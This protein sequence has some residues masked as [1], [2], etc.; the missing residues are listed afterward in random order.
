MIAKRRVLAFIAP[1]RS[2]CSVS[3]DVCTYNPACEKIVNWSIVRSCG[4]YEQWEREGTVEVAEF[5]AGLQTWQKERYVIS[6]FLLL[7]G[8]SFTSSSWHLRWSFPLLLWKIGPVG[9]FGHV[10]SIGRICH[11]QVCT[12]IPGCTP[13]GSTRLL[14]WGDVLWWDG[15]FSACQ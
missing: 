10:R 8:V 3:L 14:H 5:S 15:R 9:L 4:E 6:L 12:I 11:L 1:L 2:R 7:L 13:R